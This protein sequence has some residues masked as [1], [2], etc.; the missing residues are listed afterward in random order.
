MIAVLL[1]L[2]V[3]FTAT[4]VV[5]DS[6]FARYD[7]GLTTYPAA[8][9]PLVTER[10]LHTYPS[11]DNTLSGYL[12]TCQADNAQNA[13]I[14][15]IP[16]HNACTDTYLWQT[17]ELLSCGWSVFAFDATGCCRSEGGSSVGFPQTVLDVNATL[18]YL[19]H[20]DNFGFENVVLLG[21]SRGGYA[22]CC[23]L[24]YDYDV[25][26]VISVS[27]INSAMEG[28]IGAAARHVGDLAYSNYGGLWLYQTLLFGSETVNLRADKVLSA[29]DT[30]VLLIHGDRDDTVPL[31]K[32]SIV[33]HR[34]Q[35]HNPNAEYCIRSSPD[36]AGHTDLLFGADGTADD[37]IIQTIDTFLKKH[38]S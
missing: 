9:Q 34:E 1:F 6:I 26:A 10:R 13:L 33:S 12:Y 18:A 36:N 4:K 31:H 38:I 16:G 29:T 19:K 8:L 30:P 28:V 20:H 21:H 3:S 32:F 22:A 5:Y 11:G 23:S 24:A 35:I 37:T 15:L 17:Q 7:C 27:G 25:S 14:V 2:A